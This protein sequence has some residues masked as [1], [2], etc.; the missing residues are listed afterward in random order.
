MAPALED[1]VAGVFGSGRAE[2][3]PATS[4]DRPSTARAA[5][6]PAAVP[7]RALQLLDLAERAL[8]AGDYAGFGRYMNE[9]RQYL[10]SQE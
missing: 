6:Q 1:A 3:T 4:T 10:R 8:R 5:T 2:T 9:L 7:R